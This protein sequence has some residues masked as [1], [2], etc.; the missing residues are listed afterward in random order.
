MGRSSRGSVCL[1]KTEVETSGRGLTGW[2]GGARN[3]ERIRQ[4][5][6][7]PLLHAKSPFPIPPT[8]PASVA[9]PGPVVHS[10]DRRSRRCTKGTGGE[11]RADW[12]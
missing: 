11:R 6:W 1:V 4:S 10:A 8:P 2:G 5:E 3:D 9:L 12:R 7:T